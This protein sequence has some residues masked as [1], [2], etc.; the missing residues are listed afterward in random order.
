[1]E[2]IKCQQKRK[3]EIDEYEKKSAKW[4]KAVRA[5][6]SVLGFWKVVKLYDCSRRGF[7][8]LSVGL[9]RLLLRPEH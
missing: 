5:R 1:M 2:K 8:I 9:Q 3:G 4:S 7:K 6:N